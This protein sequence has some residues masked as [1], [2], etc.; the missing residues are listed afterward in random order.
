MTTRV[1][2]FR[3]SRGGK[4]SVPPGARPTSSRVRKAIF[5]ILGQS[6]EGEQVLD[7]FAGAGS[8]GIEAA[9]RGAASVVFVERDREAAECV[10]RNVRRLARD[11]PTR[12]LEMDVQ[13]ALEQL[14]REG[15]RF[16]LVF[17]DPPYGGADIEP[18]LNAL[19]NR[20]ILGSAAVVVVEHSSRESIPDRCGALVRT[21]QR[22][23]GQTNVSFYEETVE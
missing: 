10:R 21:D 11:R 3:G 5:D 8:L 18:V 7:L 1:A 9:S 2:G 17:A 6:C 4:L 12:V 22:R 20:S 19:A 14:D 23:Y 16:D 13:R 15:V